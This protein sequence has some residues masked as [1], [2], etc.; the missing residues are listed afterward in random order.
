[1]LYSNIKVDV[2]K[3][4]LQRISYP[5]L[6]YWVAFRVAILLD[7]LPPESRIASN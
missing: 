6:R 1:M 3:T 5:R 7:A 4:T 2:N